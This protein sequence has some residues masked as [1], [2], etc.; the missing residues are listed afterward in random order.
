MSEELSSGVIL[1]IDLGTT[2]SLV[3]VCDD[4]GP[5]VLGESTDGTGGIVP[6]VVRFG[7][8]ES[9]LARVEAVGVPAVAQASMSPGRTVYSAKRLMGR[10]LADVEA[11]AGRL[12]YA[13]EAGEHET[14][15]VVVRDGER[16][17]RVTAQEVAAAVLRELKSRAEISLGMSFDGREVDAVI[18]VPAYFDD[19]QRQATRDAGRLAGLRVRR[20]VNEP[21]AAA[22]AYGI[23]AGRSDGET[24][25]VFDFGGGTFD[26]SVLRVEPAAEEGGTAFFEVLSTAGDTRLGGDDI[27]QL[28]IDRALGELR[29]AAV[30]SGVDASALESWEPNG[31]QKQSLRQL[32]QAVKHSLSDAM[33]TTA[34]LSADF[35]GDVVH[36]EMRVTRAAFDS[37]IEPVVDRAFHACGVA[38]RDAGLDCS[39]ID[40][41]VLVGGSTRIPLV[42]ERA[43][44]FFGAEP[45]V[46]LDPDRVVALGAA[47][48]AA[49]LAGSNTGALLLDVIPL[50]L[51]I[52]TIGGATAKLIVRNSTVP[53]RA[54]E[55]FSTSVDGQTKISLNVLQGEREMA[56]DCRSLATFVL[57]GIPPMPAGI[58]QVEVE[59]LVDAN[60][61][62]QVSALEKRSGTAATI[63]VVPNHG[64][65]EEDVDR[66]EREA[67]EHALD[68]MTRHRIVD[69]IAN[70]KLDLKWIGERL[71][72]VADEL[73]AQE[74][75][76]IEGKSAE[77][78][79]FIE[80]AEADWK[81][82]DANAFHATKQALD[83]ASIP[84]HEKSIAKSLRGG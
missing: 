32:A 79:G 47:Q 81:S 73:T 66:I 17:A 2:N 21:T 28:L 29:K 19:A 5:R 4:R 62:L 70:S 75:E 12:G 22:L 30:A 25:V 63:Q 23:G 24:I 37:L 56:E 15:R 3:A 27:D 77:L 57:A 71:P 9:G 41:V 20:I 45:Y 51:G 82:V 44:S 58:P 74:R 31:E 72:S 50:S 38:L 65:T 35:G 6:S 84:M 80:S 36:A 16:V 53:A 69:L 39:C 7:V 49:I 26:V 8:S 34:S 60:G 76:L 11:D 55:M 83:E 14:V 54:T 68:D 18:T 43:R 52:E 33:E 64:L 42:R 40:R 61:I 46:A 59:F 1:G 67:F 78:K 10:S 13:V 48:Q